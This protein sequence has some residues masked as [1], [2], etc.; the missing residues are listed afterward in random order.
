VQVQGKVR[1][2]FTA[3]AGTPPAALEQTARALPGIQKWLCGNTI[4]KVI[5]VPDKL[6]NIVIRKA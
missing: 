5:T 3:P 2:K 1:D 6:V 4:V